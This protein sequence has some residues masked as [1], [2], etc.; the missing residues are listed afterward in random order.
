LFRTSS[1]FRLG[2]IVL[3]VASRPAWAAEVPG[4]VLV[5][6]RRDVAPE[7][8]RRAVDE[9]GGRQDGGVE[10]LR[11][12]RVR[13]PPGL[14]VADAVTRLARR[15]EVEFAEPNRYAYAVS[16]AAPNDPYFPDQWA[17]RQ[18]RADRAWSDGLPGARG[19]RSVVVA[20]LDTGIRTCHPDLQGRLVAAEDWYNAVSPGQSPEDDDPG[21]HGTFV[22]GEIAAQT[23]NGIGIAGLVQDSG[24]T[25]GTGM[26]MPVKVLDSAGRGDQI[27]IA[28]G[29]LWASS[30]GAKVINMSISTCDQASGDCGN[31]NLTMLEALDA[32]H[33]AGVIAVAAAGNSSVTN[34]SYPAAYP[35]V[36]GVSATD[37]FDRLADYS[38]T[39]DYVD[40][41]APGGGATDSQNDAVIGLSA[42]NQSCFDGPLA[43]QTDVGTS[44]AAPLVSGLAAILWARFPAL[45]GDAIVGL[46]ERTADQPESAG[47]N[48]RYGF[49]RINVYRALL[50][51]A[52]APPEAASPAAAA[53]AVPN[54]F[55]P[56]GD[57]FTAF[58]VRPAPGE[59]VTVE[60]FDALGRRVWG[61]SVT[62]AEAAVTDFYFNSPMRWDGADEHGRPQA[63]GTYLARITLG[64]RRVTKRVV[65]AQ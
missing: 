29:I 34:Y 65:V 59:A 13:L 47:W 53:F 40:V 48:P 7:A 27:A 49:G 5:R 51:Q 16:L 64:E 56:R 17:L 38:N 52:S 21:G 15:P 39:G 28:N 24:V 25:G 3:S 18:I 36:V 62:A 41:A 30:H 20:I 9:L 43:Y 14:S 31:G 37:R 57:R 44:M 45:D 42:S 54:P 46:I 55:S 10:R 35:N 11:V 22:A 61:K 6:F 12:R 4:E 60:I 33:R 58:V 8:E 19:S 2:V 32:A 26:L 1:F 50:E 23:D 63:N